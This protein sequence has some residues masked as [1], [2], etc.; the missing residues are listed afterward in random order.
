MQL[1]KTTFAEI[2]TEHQGIINAVCAVYYSDPEDQ[3]DARQDIL[4][5]IWKALPSFRNESKVST[6][7]YSVALNTVLARI[8]KD[9]RNVMREP[10][11]AI[12]ENHLTVSP[13]ADDLQQQLKMIINE[14]GGTEKALII[15]YLEGYS[16]KEISGMLN[17]T[18]TNVSTKMNRIKD[19]L[20][21]MFKSRER[22]HR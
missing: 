15:L 13:F 19:K 16:H 2:I 18:E 4:I 21:Q 17:I 12:H 20:R 8:R 9:G 3:K 5:Q 22:E 1:L 10:R 11:M 14:L 6:W 7:M